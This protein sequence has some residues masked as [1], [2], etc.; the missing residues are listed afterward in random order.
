MILKNES[1]LSDLDAMDRIRTVIAG[2]RVSVD[3]NQPS[4]CFITKWADG[5]TVW[6]MRLKSGTDKFGVLDSKANNGQA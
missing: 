6:A 3:N 4:Y 2:G 5:I 1:R